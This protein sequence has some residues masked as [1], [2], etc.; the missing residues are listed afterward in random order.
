METLYAVNDSK[1][2]M[3]RA[4]ATLTVRSLDDEVVRAL[5]ILAAQHGR[6]AEAEHREILKAALIGRSEPSPRQAAAARLAE[7]R[8]R[9]SG[10]GSASGAALLEESRRGRTGDLT[11]GSGER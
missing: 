6:S 7:F 8:Q 3:E 11:G 2:S 4:V 1:R 5:R 9:V 10:R